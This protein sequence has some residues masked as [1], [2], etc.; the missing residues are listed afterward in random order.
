MKT[1]ALIVI[2]LDAF[3]IT[4]NGLVLKEIVPEVSIDGI[5]KVTEADFVISDDLKVM[6]FL[7][8]VDKQVLNI[9]VMGG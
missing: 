4:D 7:K 1:V 2:E 9:R 6:D 5:R 3:E 8:K